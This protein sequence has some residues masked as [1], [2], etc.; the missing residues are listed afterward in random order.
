MRDG[1]RY[2]LSI[3]IIAA[4]LLA[5]V[6]LYPV[7]LDWMLRSQKSGKPLPVAVSSPQGSQPTRLASNAANPSGRQTAS[8]AHR[9][10]LPAPRLPTAAQR[11][12]PAPATLSSPQ[13]TGSYALNSTASRRPQQH[14]S[15]SRQ[16]HQWSIKELLATGN[17]AL[18]TRSLEL[19]SEP[20]SGFFRAPAATGTPLTICR[21][22]LVELLET[23]GDWV[24]IKSASGVIGWLPQS[25]LRTS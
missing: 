8:P 7:A 24:R 23:E 17:W 6:S 16:Q 14:R 13:A 12:R 4:V 20:G 1:F 21:D 11:A 10:S 25:A 2:M 9:S 3:I 18:V 5:M 15:S 19:N 22:T